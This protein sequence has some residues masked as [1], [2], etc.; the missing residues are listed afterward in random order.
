M[1]LRFEG[2]EM[3]KEVALDDVAQVLDVFLFGEHFLSQLRA[4]QG[5]FRR[6]DCELPVVLLRRSYGAR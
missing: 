6:S 1:L 5:R 4:R 3:G 2:P